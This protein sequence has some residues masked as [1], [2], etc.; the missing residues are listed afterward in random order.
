MRRMAM[1]QHDRVGGASCGPSETTCVTVILPASHSRLRYL[2]LRNVDEMC[3]N[4]ATYQLSRLQLQAVL[5]ASDS[6]M[7]KENHW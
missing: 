4:V 3:E 2:R 5:I 6:R 1:M 7:L